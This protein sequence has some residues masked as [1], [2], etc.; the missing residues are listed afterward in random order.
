M[1]SQIARK[2]I[3][4]FHSPATRPVAAAQL[5][6]REE[7]ILQWL[8]R[9]FSNKEIAA[10]LSS[11]LETVRV[12]VRHIYDK[13]QVHSRAGAAARFFTSGQSRPPG[14]TLAA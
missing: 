3:A 10:Q 14:P 5:T 9:G 12:H 8:A 6:P 4:A 11:S 7:E 13:L 1:T 2:V